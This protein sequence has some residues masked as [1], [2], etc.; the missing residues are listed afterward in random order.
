[1]VY[2]RKTKSKVNWIFNWF[3]FIHGLVV[4]PQPN[5]Y[6]AFLASRVTSARLYIVLHCRCCVSV[7]FLFTFLYCTYTVLGYIHMSTQLACVRAWNTFSGARALVRTNFWLLCRCFADWAFFRM[8]NDFI[9]IYTLIIALFDFLNSRIEAQCLLLFCI[10]L[11]F[12]P[13]LLRSY[14][15]NI[16]RRIP[17]ANC[18]WMIDK[19]AETKCGALSLRLAKGDQAT[20]TQQI[21][22]HTPTHIILCSRKLEIIYIPFCG[23]QLYNK[24]FY[25]LS[26]G[27]W[28]SR[29]YILS[30]H[31]GNLFVKLFIVRSLVSKII[32]NYVRNTQVP[33]LKYHI[34]YTHI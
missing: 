20:S 33:W 30:I 6:T 13:L 8:M 21:F 34:Q 10:L 24:L 4:E 15:F 16:R 31:F 14:L 12:F 23:Y 9:Y 17:A 27:T 22:L 2:V 5:I 7:S 25:S 18:S 3:E 1:M 28:I 26:V 11:L 29:I 32:V 19:I